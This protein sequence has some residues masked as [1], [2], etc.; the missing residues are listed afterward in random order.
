[1]REMLVARTISFLQGQGFSVT[2]FLHTNNCFDLAAK[3]NGQVFLLK[4]LSNIDGLR[5]E[6][7]HELLR[8]SS[9]TRSP[10]FIIGEKSKSFEMRKETVYK[11]YGVNCITIETFQSIVQNDLPQVRYFKGKET[12]GIDSERLRLERKNL[13]LT[14]EQTAQ[15]IGL[16]P[17]SVHRYETGASASLD[18]AK[19]LEKFFGHGILSSI[20]V[21]EPSIEPEPAEKKELDEVFAKIEKLG[22]DLEFFSHAPFRAFSGPSEKIFL[23]RGK[24]GK[25]IRKKAIELSKAKKIIG[26]EPFIIAK[27]PREHDYQGIPIISEE[28]LFSM[29]KHKNLLEAMKKKEKK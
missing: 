5:E 9:I 20:D 16:T 29:T 24:I 4:I 22:F 21:L 11:R 18:A 25:E 8:I 6:Q 26:G 2:S 12:V 28:E 19:K 17:E 23:N 15:K 27:E 1:M 7:A 3:K 10:A 13:G 14:L